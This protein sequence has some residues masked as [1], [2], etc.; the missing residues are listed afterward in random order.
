[1]CQ[2]INFQFLPWK[3]YHIKKFYC[4]IILFKNW[5]N[6][7]IKDWWILKWKG[8]NK[9]APPSAYDFSKLK[10]KF[11]NLVII[12]LRY[13]CTYLYGRPLTNRTWSDCWLAC[14]ILYRLGLSNGLRVGFP[15]L[16]VVASVVLRVAVVV[17]LLVTI[18]LLWLKSKSK[19]KILTK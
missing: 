12:C 2:T 11:R 6:S 17:V 9:N 19:K 15:D 3:V 5:K 7:E 18:I 8:N 10:R 1:M 16:T 13:M 14:G 4:L